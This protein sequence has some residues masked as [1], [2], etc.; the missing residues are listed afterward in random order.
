M[1]RLRAEAFIDAHLSDATLDAEAIA[2][3]I[4]S[5][6]SSLYRSFSEDG[7]LMRHIQQRR[8]ERLRM[9]LRRP[10]DGRSVAAL[11]FSCGFT[12]EKHCSRAFRTAFGV[13]PGRYR[14]AI[15]EVRQDR[16]VTG[17]V[18]AVIRRWT[19]ELY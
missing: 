16:S 7:G 9:A 6:R 11:A 18:E 12:D 19:H 14:A 10:G 13:P 8:L 5:S 17:P 15:R 2:N 4:G 1:R 3:G